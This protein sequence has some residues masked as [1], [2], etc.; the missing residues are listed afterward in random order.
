ML[1][2]DSEAK[3]AY[4]FQIL[5]FGKIYEK[6]RSVLG[7]TEIFRPVFVPF[8]FEFESEQSTAKFSD[9]TVA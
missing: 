6:M 2:Y 5:D 9:K 4:Y 7:I 1:V 3:A 8:G